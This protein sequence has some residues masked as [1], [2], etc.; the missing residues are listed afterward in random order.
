MLHCGP[1]ALESL[2]GDLDGDDL[3]AIP[4]AYLSHAG[5]HGA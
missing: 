3:I 2:R 4:S 5:T 1:T